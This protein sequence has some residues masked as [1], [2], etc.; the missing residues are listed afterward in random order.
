MV[1]P[2]RD[3]LWSVPGRRRR[4]AAGLG[5]RR[6]RASRSR[7]NRPDWPVVRLSAGRRRRWS[8]SRRRLSLTTVGERPGRAGPGHRAAGPARPPG[9]DPRWRRRGAAAARSGTPTPCWSPRATALLRVPLAGGDPAAVV[10]R[11]CPATPSRAGA[12]R[13][14]R[15][16]RVGG[17]PVELCGRLRRP[18]RPGSSTC[19][20]PVPPSTLVFRVNRHVIVLND[21]ATGNVW[22]VD[23]DMKLISNWDDVQPQ[24]DSSDETSKDGDQNT[25]D[26]LTNSRADCVRRRHRGQAARGGRRRVRGAGRPDHRAAGAGQR[27]VGGLLDGG[28][29]RRSPP[30]P[31]RGRERWRSPNPGRPCRSPS[32]PA[33]TGPLPAVTY[34]VDDGLG[35]Q[36]TAQVTV[37][38]RRG[39][40][41]PAR[42]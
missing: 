9:A 1:A 17:R 7:R 27:R 16:R 34:T 41:T 18:T 22:L 12:A 2:G 14:V 42:R 25:S 33:A 15:A 21:Q 31:A 8:R 4:S 37:T 26:Q 10:G 23:A 24:Q 40:T 39:R 38:R 28:D 6:R 20:T 35:R 11:R 19:R 36:S 32:P 29:Q 5:D 30:L 13:R 3:E